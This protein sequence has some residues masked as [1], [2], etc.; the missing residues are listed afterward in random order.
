MLKP[1]T[2]PNSSQTA[3]VRSKEQ[4]ARTCPNSGC[5]H[6]TFHTEPLWA[7]QLAVKIHLPSLF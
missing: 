7:F 5:A 3:A 6:V 4:V 2:L 1:K